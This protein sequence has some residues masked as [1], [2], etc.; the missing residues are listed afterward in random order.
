MRFYNR[1]SIPIIFVLSSILFHTTNLK[2]G[3]SELPIKGC[4]E[5]TNCMFSEEI[6]FAYR[7]SQQT[8]SIQCSEGFISC[9]L[10]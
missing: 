6:C 8:C 7:W 1:I 3:A 5:W 9:Q 4:Y 10:N 2:I